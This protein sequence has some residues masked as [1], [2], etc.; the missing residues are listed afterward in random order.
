M[1]MNVKFKLTG[2]EQ[3]DGKTR[4]HWVA[5]FCDGNKTS[6][7]VGMMDLESSIEGKT[8]DEI[9]E[10]A[11]SLQG[12]LNLV[13]N[14]YHIHA[15]RLRYTPE[16]ALFDD[17]YVAYRFACEKQGLSF[18]SKEVALENLSQG[19][20][21]YGLIY[22]HSIF[23]ITTQ[24]N[25]SHTFHYNVRDEFDPIGD[26]NNEFGGMAYHVKVREGVAC[27][28][29]K[30]C[31]TLKLN[32][33]PVKWLALDLVTGQPIEYY[34]EERLSELSLTVTKYDVNT[35]ELMTTTNHHFGGN[36]ELPADFDSALTALNFA[37]R[38]RIFGFA[39]KSYGKI[40]EY[41]FVP[42]QT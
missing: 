33:L 11:L 22:N 38:S 31:P 42:P 1:T 24:G 6:T 17:W 16:L 37:H 15:E 9:L 20:G 14:L 40:V 34:L 2:T 12:G 3:V 27:E 35:H 36:I 10:T 18:D 7:G 41:T 13:D 28:W 29:Y 8:D 26:P 5:G 19:F 4:V 25:W 39:E 30:H 23:N 21:N 32:D